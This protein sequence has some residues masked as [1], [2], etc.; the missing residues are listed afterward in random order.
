MTRGYVEMARGNA[1]AA[2]EWNAGAPF[3]F[4]AGIVNGV[5]V[6]GYLARL[7]IKMRR[8]VKPAE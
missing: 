8:K 5:V 6:C 2:M 1:V 4:L 3:L 7:C